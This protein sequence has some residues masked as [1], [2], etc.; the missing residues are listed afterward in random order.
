MMYIYLLTRKTPMTDYDQFDS[1]VV[2]AASEEAAK[3][4]HPNCCDTVTN[5]AKPWDPW[6]T[7]DNV[8]VRLLGT[9]EPGTEPHV[10]CASFNAG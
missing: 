8:E 7:L 10:I 4:M 1:A 5:T 6:V 2:A 3:A 9:A